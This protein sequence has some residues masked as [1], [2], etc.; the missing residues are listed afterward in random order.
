MS[1]TAIPQQTIR[2][3]DASGSYRERMFHIKEDMEAFVSRLAKA[4]CQVIEL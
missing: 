3:Y 1:K 2:Y 4:G